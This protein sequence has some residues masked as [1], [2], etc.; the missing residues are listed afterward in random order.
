MVSFRS[1]FEISKKQY[2]DYLT[3]IKI[4]KQVVQEKNENI[5]MQ[6][7]E[8]ESWV[9]LHNKIKKELREKNS[10]ISHLETRISDFAK[11]KKI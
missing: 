3:Q 7:N 8:V 2:L 4:L 6:F 5:L 9:V 1:E 11:R 10:H